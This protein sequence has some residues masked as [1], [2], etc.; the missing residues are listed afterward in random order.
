MSSTRRGRRHH[1]ELFLALEMI[2]I[3]VR[4]SAECWEMAAPLHLILLKVSYCYWQF[5]PLVFRGQTLGFCQGP[6]DNPVNKCCLNKEVKEL[7][8]EGRE[9]SVFIPKIGL[10]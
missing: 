3:S 9:G 10:S 2:E 4:T 6:R 7:N 5:F 8:V 1:R